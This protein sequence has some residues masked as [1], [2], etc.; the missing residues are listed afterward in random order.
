MVLKTTSNCLSPLGHPPAAIPW[1]E[2][3]TGFLSKYSIV[4]ILYICKRAAGCFNCIGSNP[5]NKQN[6]RGEVGCSGSADVEPHL[7]S[8]GGVSITNRKPFCGQLQRQ[9]CASDHTASCLNLSS[10]SMPS[11][12]EMSI[13]TFITDQMKNNSVL[14]TGSE[15]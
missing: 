6:Q 15:S 11:Q 7:A 3:R 1:G 10:Y 12:E 2:L 5:H 13:I 8:P 14:L 9:T 4:T